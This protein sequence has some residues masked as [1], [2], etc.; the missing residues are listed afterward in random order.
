M[1]IEG[2]K[3]GFHTVASV[4][5]VIV[6]VVAGVDVSTGPDGARASS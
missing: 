6:I 5:I 1:N 4:V 3:K 2:K